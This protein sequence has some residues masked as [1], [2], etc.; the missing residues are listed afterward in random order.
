MPSYLEKTGVEYI[1][2]E[3]QVPNT[4]MEGSD[5]N[6][7]LRIDW[8]DV[9]ETS[10]QNIVANTEIS[11][12]AVKVV[13][14]LEQGIKVSG[15]TNALSEVTKLNV[16]KITS[17]EQYDFAVQAL[18]GQTNIDLYELSF[19]I[20]S[21]S[22]SLTGA[23]DISFP[24]TSLDGIY[25]INNSGSKTILYG[26]QN[27][28]DYY[29]TTRTVG[30][31][32]VVNGDLYEES[33]TQSTFDDIS[34]HWAKENIESA[35]AMGL[36]NGTSQTA[37]S[38]DAAMTNEM[39]ITVLYRIA[40]QPEV[41]TNETLWYSK[42]LEWGMENDI[43][44]GYNDFVIGENVTREALATMIYKYEFSKGEQL[45]GA[46]LSSYIDVEQVSEWAF[47]G[48]AWANANGIVNGKL[49]NNLAPQDNATRAE[50]ATMFCRYVGV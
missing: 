33:I 30:L 25:R 34:S 44:G 7:R 24:Y 36:F 21:E 17:G 6:A 35:V 4:P 16:V 9:I 48:L 45:T 29:I 13:E 3:I 31:F 46:D 37:F 38:P 12:G 5:L 49:N 32:A 10:E 41:S 43:I 27:D 40:G 23:V 50:V 47:D 14:L 20:G 8:N 22:A 2:I 42:A 19:T 15:N 26:T 11:S 39:A 28:T 18:D 1:N